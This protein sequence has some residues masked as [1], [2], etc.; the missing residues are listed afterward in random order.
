LVVPLVARVLATRSC[1]PLSFLHSRMDL[2]T[3]RSRSRATIEHSCPSTI[4]YPGSGCHWHSTSWRRWSS[5][6]GHSAP[7]TTQNHG[8]GSQGPI[9]LVWTP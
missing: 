2:C 9:Q 3:I 8:Y 1:L 5:T 7:S 4:R 6:I